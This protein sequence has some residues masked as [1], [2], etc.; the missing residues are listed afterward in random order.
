M[1]IDWLNKF[2]S[3]FNRTSPII[4]ITPRIGSLGDGAE[5]IYYGLSKA[6]RE[7]KRVLF[8]SHKEIPWKFRLPVSNRELLKIESPF[9]VDSN[10][11]LPTFLEWLLT[12]FFT[13]SHY[14]Y[15]FWRKYLTGR[16][17]VLKLT[18]RN[19]RYR[20]PTIGIEY[21]WNPERTCLFSWNNIQEERWKKEYEEYLPV[22]MNLS[23]KK[24]AEVVRVNEMG[25]PLEDWFVCLHVREPGFKKNEPQHNLLRNANILNYLEGIKLITQKGGWVVR[26]GDPTMTPLP[27][28]DHVIDYALSPM[29]NSLM[30]IYL[31]QECR[32]LIGTNSG[33]YDLARL[34]QKREL[35]IN[36][37]EWFYT[38]PIQKRGRMITKHFF[39]TLLGRFL[40]I[41][42]MFEVSPD[43]L[44]HFETNIGA[45][46]LYENTV[47]EIRD[48]VEE[49]LEEPANS[50]HSDLQIAANKARR[51]RV[52]NWI[53]GEYFI[54]NYPQFSSVEQKYRIASKLALQGTLSDS[55]L[56]KY[57]LENKPF[58]NVQRFS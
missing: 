55:F 20:C 32:F 5:E 38:W 40:S 43:C 50:S 27:K 57:W 44:Y 41:Q 45:Y 12:F 24:H 48:A 14:F 28:M 47:D 26:L 7:G 46:K 3:F 39:S 13:V 37:S 34:L 49:F 8:L 11:F 36:V 18:P 25:I 58:E 35:L 9:A 56:K 1:L 15:L 52:L 42:E 21:L 54:S 33:P 4:V 31:M 17:Q 19:S 10:H 23:K 29:K 30:D 22:F 53:D 2:F 16:N 6:R 51:N